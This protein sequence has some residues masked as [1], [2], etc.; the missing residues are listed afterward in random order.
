MEQAHHRRAAAI[1]GGPAAL[2]R[3][4]RRVGMA[5]TLAAPVRIL[6]VFGRLSDAVEEQLVGAVGG[7]GQRHPEP[8]EPGARPR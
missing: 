6:E 8:L 5:Q 1:D 3:R 4:H 7:E 2:G